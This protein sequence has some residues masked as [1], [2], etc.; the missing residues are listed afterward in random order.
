MIKKIILTFAV[1]G[2]IIS[3]AFS[4][5][6]ISTQSHQGGVNK[7][8]SIPTQNVLDYSYFS[9]GEDGFLVKWS[10]DNQGEHYQISDVGIKLI[11]VS[12]NGNDIAVYETDG[13]SVNK[14]SIWD[15]RNLTR[16]W[17]KNTRIP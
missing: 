2:L 10:D 9:I 5:A 13:G 14:V 11:S 16:K 15:W 1:F 3:S 8:I 17:Q 6:H 7:L 4:Q 12:P